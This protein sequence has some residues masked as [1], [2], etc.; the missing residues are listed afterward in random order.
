MPRR[1]GTG[2]IGKGERT[3]KG[4]GDCEPKKP[5]KKDKKK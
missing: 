3:G 4:Y 5:V 1:D 2:P